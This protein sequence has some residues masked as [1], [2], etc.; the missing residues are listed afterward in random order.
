MNT[1]DN[2]QF[3]EESS[4]ELPSERRL[5]SWSDPTTKYSGMKPDFRE[6]Q[7]FNEKVQFGLLSPTF[8]NGRWNLTDTNQT[9]EEIG[10][11]ALAFTIGEGTKGWG[12]ESILKAKRLKDQYE[13]T[14]TA[15][16]SHGGRETAHWEQFTEGFNFFN[17]FGENESLQSAEEIKK[18]IQTVDSNWNDEKRLQALTQWQ[19][20]NR[21]VN[22]FIASAGVNIQD[23]ALATRNQDAFM[24]AIN[25]A[26]Q[27][28]R[29]NV[30]M[31]LF[32]EDNGFFSKLGN[33]IAEGI[34]DPLMV[35]DMVLTSAATLGLGTVAGIAGLSS[36]ALAG[37]V[38]AGINSSKA[39]KGLE[40]ARKAANAAT[41]ATGPMTGLIEGPAYVAIRALVPG[42]GRSAIKTM[43]ARGLALALEGGTAGAVSSYEDQ[44][45]DHEWRSLVFKDTDKVFKYNLGETA[46]G[47]LTGALGAVG[48]A[49]AF[50]FGLGAVGDYKYYKT[51][52]WDGL[53]RQIANSMDTWATT[54]D[55]DIVWGNTLSDGRGIFFGDVVDNFMKRS[56]GRDF[57][58]VMLNGSRLF[59][60]FNERI[61][62]KMNLDVKKV[63]PII[64]EFEKATGVAGEAAMLRVD[65]VAPE[66]R[67]LFDT[68]LDEKN[69]D[70]ADLSLDDV[71]TLLQDYNANR[72]GELVGPR[73]VTA[74]EGVLE[75]MTP[76]TKQV[77][78]AKQI[79]RLVGARSLDRKLETIGVKSADVI[80][81]AETTLGRSLNLARDED[82]GNFTVAAKFAAASVD[83]A[84]VVN[85]LKRITSGDFGGG[86]T[87][88]KEVV[89]SIFKSAFGDKPLVV[90]ATGSNKNFAVVVDP[91]IGEVFASGRTLKTNRS[92]NLE[93]ELRADDTTSKFFTEDATTVDTDTFRAKLVEVNEKLNEAW[94]K[95]VKSK[96]KARIDS[97]KNPK[98]KAEL[99]ATFAEGKEVTV[100]NIKEVFRLTKSEAVA[101]KIIFDAL[102]YEGDSGMLRIAR[103][104]ADD[105]N[106]EIVLE[107]S[108]ALIRATKSADMGTITHEMSHYLQVMVLDNMD[109]EARHAI[110]ITDEMWTKFKDWVGFTGDEWSEQAAEKFANGMSQYVRRVMAGD[111]RAPTTQV[112]RLFHRVGD[113]LGKLGDRFKTQ[114]ALEAGLTVSAEAEAVFEA[115]FNRSNSKIGELFDGAYQNLFKRLPKEQRHAIGKEILGEMAFN[116]YLAKKEIETAKAKAVIDPLATAAAVK[117]ESTTK[118][119]DSIYE[120]I[121]K[122]VTR[123]N[124]KEAITI[125]GYTKE[126]YLADVGK[127]RD[128]VLGK[129]NTTSTKPAKL[130]SAVS[131]SD[132]EL[133]TL[134]TDLFEAQG[135]DS[136]L[137]YVGVVIDFDVKLGVVTD[138]KDL[139]TLDELGGK[140]PEKPI[141]GLTS[142]NEKQKFYSRVSLLNEINRRRDAGITKTEKSLVVSSETMQSIDD[143]LADTGFVDSAGL[144]VELTPTE[145][146]VATRMAAISAASKG[147][148]AHMET[149]STALTEG[150]TMDA[151]KAKKEE[152]VVPDVINVEEKPVEITTG[153]TT[154]TEIAAAAKEETT[155]L[156]AELP[157][158][159]V[160]E[161]KTI[162][163]AVVAS[164]DRAEELLIQYQELLEGSPLGGLT[165]QFVEA[166]LRSRIS[167]V[168][169]EN[170]IGMDDKV[171][172]RFTEL[173]EIAS[174]TVA[175]TSLFEVAMRSP[176]A[177][178]IKAAADSLKWTEE[179]VTILISGRLQLT[180]GSLIAEFIDSNNYVVNNIAKVEEHRKTVASQT[181]EYEA[182]KVTLRENKSLTAAEKTKLENLVTSHEKLKSLI[183]IFTNHA[184]RVKQ[185]VL[186]SESIDVVDAEMKLKADEPEIQTEWLK[187]ANQGQSLKLVK[188]IYSKVEEAD[189]AK[190]FKTIDSKI[191]TLAEKVAFDG[192]SSLPNWNSLSPLEKA[193]A[194]AAG[195]AKSAS[196]SA[197]VKTIIN[198]EE[199]N[200]KRKG[201][202]KK[203]IVGDVETPDGRGD[204]I[205]DTGEARVGR[206]TKEERQDFYYKL[207]AESS[208]LRHVYD[209]FYNYLVDSGKDEL[210][211]VFM[212]RK[213]AMTYK[214]SET[215]STARILENFGITLTTKTVENRILELKNEFERFTDILPTEKA[216]ELRAAL[217]LAKKET[218]QKTLAQ[219]KVAKE[220]TD[221]QLDELDALFE[222]MEM[223]DAIQA[224]DFLINAVAESS[225]NLYKKIASGEVETVG[226]A[227]R[228]LANSKSSKVSSLAQ[229]LLSEKE[230]ILNGIGLHLAFFEDR[231]TGGS[232]IGNNIFLNAKSN[233]VN[234]ITLIHETIHA[235]TTK[236]L[237]SYGFEE[238]G[239][240]NYIQQLTD[241]VD[242][243][244]GPNGNPLSAG[245]TSI[246]KAYLTAIS[247]IDATPRALDMLGSDYKNKVVGQ[248]ISSPESTTHYALSNIHEFVAVVL[249]DVNAAKFFG[250]VPAEKTAEARPVK[251][252]LFGVA[253]TLWLE[254]SELEIQRRAD[255]LRKQVLADLVTGAL[256]SKVEVPDVLDSMLPLLLPDTTA[257]KVVGNA[258]IKTEGRN[259]EELLRANLKAA[260]GR[261]YA[262][263][264]TGIPLDKI[265]QEQQTFLSRG[266]HYS[267]NGK[268]ITLYVGED[269]SGYKRFTV[270]GDKLDSTPAHIAVKPKDVVICRGMSDEYGSIFLSD[271]RNTTDKP[272]DISNKLPGLTEYTIDQV[273]PILQ[274]AGYSV[275]EIQSRA[276]YTQTLILDPSKVDIKTQADNPILF[277][278]R[279]G[280]DSQEFKSWFAGSTVTTKD[281]QPRV[282]YHGSPV[283]GF[284]SFN[285]F[286]GTA[287]LYGPGSYFTDSPYVAGTYALKK[288]KV[289]E[290]SG[291]Y[292]VY[293]SI[294]N[295]LVI[296][297]PV[298]ITLK[299]KLRDLLNLQN[300]DDDEISSSVYLNNAE[301]VVVDFIYYL[302]SSENTTFTWKDLYKILREYSD[303]D[304]VTNFLETLGYDGI[305]H[306]GGESTKQ[307][308][309]HRVYIAFNPPQIKS[310]FSDKF[311]DSVKIMAQKRAVD[312]QAQLAEA[313]KAS[314]ADAAEFEAKLAELVD[315]TEVR[316][317][318]LLAAGL[319]EEMEPEDLEIIQSMINGTKAF[320]QPATSHLTKRMKSAV[321]SAVLPTKFVGKSYRDLTDDER[322]DFVSSVMLPTIEEKM[323]KRNRSAG[324]YSMITDSKVG[325]GINSLIGGGAAYGDTADSESLLLQFFSKIYDPLMDL[326]DGELSGVYDLFSV[327]MLNAETNN[328][329]SRAGLL[330]IQRKIMAQVTNPVELE[331]LYETAWMYLGNL[332]ELPEGIAHR[333]LIIELAKGV[334]KYNTIV[335]DILK[336]YGSLDEAMDPTKYG[337]IHKVNML[338]F[339]EQERFVDALVKHALAK[340][341]ASKELSIVTMDALGWVK[342][343][344]DSVSDDIKS[345]S[346]PED[347]PLAKIYKE[348]EYDYSDFKKVAKK[349]SLSKD[350]LDIHDD[351][352]TS[353][354]NYKN[355]DIYKSRGDS[356]SALRHTMTVAKNRYLDIES[357]ESRGGK[358]RT[359]GV[360]GGR[361]MDITRILSHEEITKNPELARYF[362]KDIFGLIN[363]QL[364]SSVTDAIMTKYI[365]ETFGVKMSFL[366]LVEVARKHGEASRGQLTKSEQDSINHGYDRV[367]TIWEANTGRLLA[368]RDGLDRHYK[369]LLET[370]SRPLVLAASGLRAAVTSTGETVRAILQSNHNKGM[371]TQ[372]IPNFINTLK[373]F[374]RKKRQTIQ[375]VASATH[376]IRGLSSDHLLLR[377]EMNPNNPF[378][379]TIMG[380]KQGGWF[381]RWAQAWQGVKERNK[382][383][384]SIVGKTANYLS[385]PA[386]KLGAPLAFVN[387]VTTT[388]HVQN[389]QHNLTINGSKFL[390]LAKLLQEVEPDSVAEFKELARRAGLST[391]EAIDL[392]SM[393]LLDPKRVEVMIEAA[394]D[395]RN[396][397][398]GMLDVQRLYLWAGDDQTK[399]DTI[400]RMGGLINA[401][402]RHT[403]TDPTLLDL[404]IN[405]SAYARSMGVFMQFLLSHSTQEIGR[406]RRYTTTA[407]S[408]HLAGLV[409][410]EAIAYSLAR[411]KDDDDDKWIWDD[412][413]EKPF[414]TVVKLGTSLPLLGSYQ[415]LSALLRAGILETHSTLTGEKSEERYRTPDLFSGPSENIPRKAVDMIKDLL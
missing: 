384:D 106:A 131:L 397:M 259:V 311:T 301:E 303:L 80:S 148:V 78:I 236:D 350:L 25:E 55:G 216:K 23:F 146:I 315:S 389:L 36:R 70:D 346:I 196:A 413:K 348:T 39:V 73:Q 84:Q 15:M 165:R 24:F 334:H 175:T 122:S 289:G 360:G 396:Y 263:L 270:V 314:G 140:I 284:D 320:T 167:V 90:T 112:Q 18:K 143:M 44:Q 306:T 116:D 40:L 391:K 9:R 119:I 104:A 92:G 294:K 75:T 403:N 118:I 32:E 195:K 285:T 13:N 319:H 61:A 63:M 355:W 265:A 290:A 29:I 330:N 110:G 414:Q 98:A 34:K 57:T 295:P 87:I 318:N 253:K 108:T 77:E 137:E 182:A 312:L 102:G 212:A 210:A 361:E 48:I 5:P 260:K 392:S 56:D 382:L 89:Q 385:V 158:T 177:D 412:A 308:Y 124:I 17:V 168:T 38:S 261:V 377:A 331:K 134:Y 200:A 394:K 71:K 183:S 409:M 224:P 358:P 379:G 204:S 206:N 383:E 371:L 3:L 326:R 81:S 138:A 247:W 135:V 59:G 16:F 317:R 245:A 49:T 370:G 255:F 191:E 164:P 121:N 329:Y 305:T 302:N 184:K 362:D 174:Q 335:G 372:V 250:A 170:I 52:D 47:A 279:F 378:G 30:G 400:N 376:W 194:W 145:S 45:A 111:G 268:P 257:F 217:S 336:K 352:L 58:N 132:D 405:Q 136:S 399:I 2:E 266:D 14:G 159:A 65:G 180:N 127:L 404:R 393:G 244:V 368:S 381:K 395:Q 220:L 153:L 130:D 207:D 235:L 169:I 151:A 337:T 142:R 288:G 340:E 68:I 193:E 313:A 192:E 74:A 293:L 298:P 150:R 328:M 274:E 347:S 197:F 69:L 202:T 307:P 228:A 366:D 114:E 22:N 286:G 309:K 185:G 46:M 277:M 67:R 273:S 246:I 223:G 123:K 133:A 128:V 231:F 12:E 218:K 299:E 37:G 105:R 252:M 4:R 354:K 280:P 222:T 387:D 203:G 41:L 321:S 373:L 187:L 229:L 219:S 42:T 101:A 51:G 351:G 91:K 54:K 162:A 357:A 181:T 211:K 339:E 369:S 10:D 258:L 208:S 256:T 310:I 325:K 209:L 88:P 243:G 345:V 152:T 234:V 322:R 401:T 374:S 375:Q 364:R 66:T 120:G 287:G 172:K 28:A 267:I 21:E 410:M 221:E 402:A 230:E 278:E 359:E 332:E 113:H 304:S 356:Y 11:A 147:A 115:L 94:S 149:V 100:E 199:A 363:Q 333:E 349:S 249:T 157:A 233:R 201:K 296:E 93:I 262:Q 60:K 237:D 232:F 171:F 342:L 213:E 76:A 282:M 269:L 156:E 72:S 117:T 225:S 179:D 283:T 323:G 227:L 160:K 240:V 214:G 205:I 272:I 251:E 398:E 26:V 163:A 103:F 344:R 327:D 35:R 109:A 406:R 189:P 166:E 20:S 353:S 341:R 300:Q 275:L 97:I 407:Y 161:A 276:G 264:K 125:G 239:A 129:K 95:D 8:L 226:D 388:L 27:Q 144:S 126:E 7:I 343:T 85:T 367:K 292:P 297:D 139:T 99:A 82:F 173:E 141:W 316:R 19:E 53:R 186:R 291:I 215:E 408:K 154:L 33:S 242:S 238:T 6:Q 86:R 241:A 338:A 96:V 386:S 79:Q 254:G 43:S 190:I 31:R 178:N 390:A 281:G 411:T 83:E 176:T 415:Y 64:E 198:N 380:A 107:G 50:R 155:R 365:T 62:G 248:T 324:I 1:F 188:L 271:L